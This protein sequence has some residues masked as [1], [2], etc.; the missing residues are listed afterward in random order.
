[1]KTLLLFLS[2]TVTIFAQSKEDSLKQVDIKNQYIGIMKQ[3]AST[4]SLSHV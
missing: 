2:L 1:M 4:D 3:K